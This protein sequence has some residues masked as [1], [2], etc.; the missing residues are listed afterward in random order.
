MSDSSREIRQYL[1]PSSG[2]FWKW[3]DAGEV[4]VWNDGTTILFRQELAEILS[5]LVPQGLPPLDLLLILVAGMRVPVHDLELLE[6]QLEAFSTLSYSSLPIVIESNKQGILESGLNKVQQLPAELRSRTEGKALIAESVFDFYGPRTTSELAQAIVKEVSSGLEEIIFD[7]NPENRQAKLSQRLTLKDVSNFLTGLEQLD[8]ERLRLRRSTGLDE[9]PLPET[10]EIPFADQIRQ[11]IAELKDD[12]EHCS[13]ARLAQNLLAAVSIPRPVAEPE[14]LAHG[15]VSDICNRGP[16]DRLLLSELANDDLTLT[17]RI[18]VNE[19]L[20]LRREASP[21]PPQRCRT[22]LI[23]CGIRT[24]GIPRVY[25]AAVALALAASTD[26][27]T[28]FRA[29]RAFQKQL[30]SVELNSREG[31]EELLQALDSHLHPAFALPEFIRQLEE[32]ESDPE[33]VLL[34]TEDTWHDQEFQSALQATDLELLHIATVKRNGHFQ[35]IEK[36]PRGNKIVCELELDLETLFADSPATT[37]SLVNREGFEGL[38]AILS[39]QPFPLNLAYSFYQG[40][41][42]SWWVPGYGQIGVTDS[43]LLLYWP[44]SHAGAQLLAYGIPHMKS[45]EICW[46]TGIPYQGRISLVAGNLQKSELQIIHV[47]LE[48]KHV[49]HTPIELNQMEFTAICAHHGF[50]FLINEK[51]HTIIA[52]DPATGERVGSSHYPSDLILSCDRFFQNMD[53][54]QWQALSFD[55]VQGRPVLT[56]FSLGKI[57]PADVI[58]IFERDPDIGPVCILRTG[59]KIY[60]PAR[61]ELKTIPVMDSINIQS[62]TSEDISTDGQIIAIQL[63]LSSSWDRCV[64]NLYSMQAEL[65]SGQPDIR[66]WI[67]QPAHWKR[68]AQNIRKKFIGILVTESGDLIL[69][70]N[71]QATFRITYHEYLKKIMLQSFEIPSSDQRRLKTFKPVKHD[72]DLGCQLSVATWDDGSQAFLD[73]RGMLHLK[74][75]D[76]DIPEASLCLVEDR[77][78][79]WCHDGRYWGTSYFCGENQ[80]TS[81]EKIFVSVIRKF[82][83]QLK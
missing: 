52:I 44:K 1:T 10:L 63:N 33:P 66:K 58:T 50:L 73:S 71:K 11:L 30:E 13:L 76:Y 59:G 21:H 72:Q 48:K 8:V 53:R 51:F 38:P 17:V 2:A 60:F 28:E 29:Y 18:A 82:G 31:L 61:E 75:A 56:E 83:E 49:V 64:L 42:T 4:I 9:L 15:G 54:N 68:S 19:A 74:S 36:S 70:S 3:A 62:I 57:N 47:D 81:P 35:L 25:L 26:Q 22:L 20:Y 16:L 67:N 46:K 24:W 32:V 27:Q 55:M 78:S 5:Y 34:I 45:R 6:E 7:P 40:K 69:K 39:T 79:G 37:N 43:G 14:D 65:K 41:Q 23:D 80:C 12:Q 77:I